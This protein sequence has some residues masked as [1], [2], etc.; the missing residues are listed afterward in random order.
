MCLH[1]K[2][3]EI[4]ALKMAQSKTNSKITGLFSCTVLFQFH[5]NSFLAYCFKTKERNY[6]KMGRV[7]W[8]EIL[9]DWRDYPFL[10]FLNFPVYS[11]SK[12]ENFVSANPKLLT[13]IFKWKCCFW[14]STCGVNIDHWNRLIT[15]VFNFA[16]LFKNSAWSLKL[17]NEIISEVPQGTILGP[18]LFSI[19]LCDLF[20]SLG[21]NYFTNYAD[22]ATF[23]LVIGNNPEEVV[24]ELKDLTQ[25]VYPKPNKCHIPLSITE[26]LYFQISEREIVICNSYSKKLLGVTFDDKLR[27]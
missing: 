3:T 7:G 26:E 2:S 17:W 27:F 12:T 20:L 11:F 23:Y 25:K 19:F 6:L 24:F 1:G 21:N 8:E 13:K 5:F 9:F 4:L 10:Q 14:G 22:D 15:S 16:N 18:F